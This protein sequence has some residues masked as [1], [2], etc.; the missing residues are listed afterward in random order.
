MKVNFFALDTGVKTL[1]HPIYTWLVV[2]SFAALS[3]CAGRTYYE[4]PPAMPVAAEPAR[5]AVLYNGTPVRFVWRAAD[6][7]ESYDFHI[8]DRTTGDIQKYSRLALKPASVCVQQ[9]CS[10]SVMLNMP[11]DDGHAW[12]VRAYN[13][14]GNSS[15]TRSIFQIT[16]D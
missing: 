8:F 1:R 4:Q 3:S 5:D 10:V 12:R 7:A 13:S 14:A 9:I 6:N 2:A 11:I 15:W 16:P